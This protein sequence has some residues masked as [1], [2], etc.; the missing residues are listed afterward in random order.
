MPQTSSRIQLVLTRKQF[1]FVNYFSC[2][3]SI[4][5]RHLYKY[6]AS[7]LKHVHTLYIYICIQEKNIRRV[8]EK[9][10]YSK[11]Y[12]FRYDIRMCCS[13]AYVLKGRKRKRAG[14][15]RGRYI[16]IYTYV[17]IYIYTYIHNI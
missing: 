16:Y 7:I 5:K 6:K 12:F 10:E 13:H 17:H 9:K 4:I 3:M 15:D 2:D 14:S 8:R 1:A 11:L